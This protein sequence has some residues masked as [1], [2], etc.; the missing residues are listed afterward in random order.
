LDPTTRRPKYLTRTHQGGKRDA[1]E[2][3]ARFVTEVSG[4]GH[5]AQDTTVGDLIREWF[6]LASPEL[7][8]TT[9][10]GYDWIIK[11]YILPTLESVPLGKL[12]TAQLDRLYV[13]LRDEG[14]RDG[15]NLSAATVRQVHAI[16]RRALQQGVR[17]GWISSN[18]AALASPPRVRR[19]EIEPPDPA[20]VVKLIETATTDNPDFGC[21]LYIAATTGARRGEICGLHW[22]AI[23][24]KNRTIV[25]SRSLVEGAHGV[26][27]E[28]ETKTGSVRRVAMDERGA[29]LLTEQLRRCR[30]RARRSGQTLS[31]NA[32]VFSSDVGGTRPWV[33]ND[34]TKDFI[35]LRN[36]VGLKNVRLHDLRHYSATR[37]LA[38]GVPV[39]TV[40]GRLGH[41]N[42]STTLGVYA[43]FIAGSDRDAADVIGDE[44]T[45]ERMMP[46]R[47]I[48]HG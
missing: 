19:T 45:K 12:R 34:V 24:L 20:A 14:G 39:R 40:S 29:D 36:R 9:V 38:A 13:K 48:A 31:P 28:K 6:E 22:D 30:R 8:P 42:A 32:Y 10:K 18:P 21:F 23:D 7:S 16:V 11:T 15:G 5:R 41:A 26:M 46:R 4:G 43:H 44:L 17:W 3:L 33:P 2:A 27:V 1:Q 25:I 37:L 35:R 47:R